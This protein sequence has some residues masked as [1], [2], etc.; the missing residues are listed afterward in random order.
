MAIW[1]DKFTIP[2][3]E[4]DKEHLYIEVKNRN[5]TGSVLIGRCKLPCNEATTTPV[6]NWYAIFDEGGHKAGEVLLSISRS[7]GRPA[8]ISTTPRHA[9]GAH[10]MGADA[11]PAVNANS[12]QQSTHAYGQPVSAQSSMPVMSPASGATPVVSGQ[13]VSHEP[14]T[15]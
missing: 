1:N 8:P 5:M 12:A 7:T 10:T 11:T 9:T 6:E 2:V 14:P 15:V 13:P 4:F 3:Q